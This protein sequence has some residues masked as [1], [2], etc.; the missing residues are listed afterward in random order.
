LEKEKAAARQGKLD[1]ALE[2]QGAAKQ[3][4]YE[5]LEKDF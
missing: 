1:C 4:D 5:E 3:V 2:G